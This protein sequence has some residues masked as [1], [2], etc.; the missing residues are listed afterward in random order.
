MILGLAEDMAEYC[1]VFPTP[2]QG[3]H[4]LWILGHLAHGEGTL[5]H[6][7]AFG[8]ANPLGE[9]KSVFDSGTQPVASLDVYPDF[10]QVMQNCE[11]IRTQ[12]C[13]MLQR[14]AESDLDRPSRGVPDVY[15]PFFRSVRDCFNMN[16]LHWLEH[17]GQ[18]A[19]ARRAAGLSVKFA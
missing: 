14:L 3:N 7:W 11:S 18:L 1:L 9:W 19:D 15:R 2:R 8:Q 4:A 6:Q 12:S 5:I 13:E 17:K 16:A 10:D